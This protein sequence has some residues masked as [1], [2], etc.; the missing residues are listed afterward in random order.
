MC[1]LGLRAHQESSRIPGQYRLIFRCG[2]LW[3]YDQ[4]RDA[5]LWLDWCRH[6][7]HRPDG[8]LVV[9]S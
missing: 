1:D 8:C 5:V 2:C 7:D 9:T 6:P 4:G 3:V